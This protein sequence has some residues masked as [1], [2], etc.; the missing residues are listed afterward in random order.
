M[1]IILGSARIDERGKISGGKAGDQKQTSSTNDTKGEVSMQPYYMHSKGWFGFRFKKA[2]HA[3]KMAEAMKQAC[4]NKNIGYDQNDRLDIMTALKKYGTL[5]KIAEPTECDCSLLIRACI[6]QATG[7]DVGVFYTGNQATVL[8]NSGLFYEK[9]TVTSLT[10]LYDGDIL[11]TKTKGHTVAVVSG[12]PRAGA[13][14]SST[15]SGTKKT[16]SGKFPELPPRGYYKFGDGYETLTNYKTQIKRLQKFL[17]WCM[18][19]DLVVDGEYGAK[20]KRSVTAFQKKYGLVA[21]GEFGSKSLA[22]AKTV[23]K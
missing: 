17:N 21:D 4:N 14:T 15:S 10:L 7:I 12:R 1:A 19:S 6:Y 11:V 2:K 8:K 18:V 3:Q 13:T 5:E 23:K 20:T 22:K 9:F 16:Y